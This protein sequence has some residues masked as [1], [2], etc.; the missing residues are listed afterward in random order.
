VRARTSRAS[1]RQNERAVWNVAADLLWIIQRSPDAVDRGAH[2]READGDLVRK[3]H[4]DRS[5]SCALTPRSVP[6]FRATTVPLNFVESG[7]RTAAGF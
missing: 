1:E 2:G 5:A 7:N 6:V 3:R 4:R